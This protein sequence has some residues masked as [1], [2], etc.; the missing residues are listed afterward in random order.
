[1]SCNLTVVSQECDDKVVPK[2]HKVH[3]VAKEVRY[4]VVT[5]NERHEKE[6]QD[7]E[8]HP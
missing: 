2:R 5:S 6:L 3:G 8:E 4:P 1:M 7:V